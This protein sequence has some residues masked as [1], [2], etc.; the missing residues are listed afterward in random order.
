MGIS[1]LELKFL[2]SQNARI[3]EQ[4]RS[5]YQEGREKTIQIKILLALITALEWQVEQ[6]EGV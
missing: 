6:Y 1:D 4:N 2:R 3:I 5:L